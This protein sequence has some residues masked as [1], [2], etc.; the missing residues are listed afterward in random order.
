MKF[1]IREKHKIPKS[2]LKKFY[3]SLLPRIR[4]IAKQCGYAIGVHGSCTRDLDLIAA[5]WTKKALQ[6]MTLAV[7]LEKSFS[8]YTKGSRGFTAEGFGNKPH[9]RKCFVI[10]LGCHGADSRNAAAIYIDLSVISTC[11]EEF[12]K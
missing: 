9:G 11:K 4:R 7:R 6:P 5:P 12:P 8:K 2:K 1:W 10:Y 3:L